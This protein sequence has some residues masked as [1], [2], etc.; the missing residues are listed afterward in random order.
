ME[1]FNIYAMISPSSILFKYKLV[2]KIKA[3]STTAGKTQ[4]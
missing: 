2:I 3:L 1:S 4:I